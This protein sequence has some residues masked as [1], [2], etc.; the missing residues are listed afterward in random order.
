LLECEISRGIWIVL[1]I[2]CIPPS[3][4][5][6]TDEGMTKIS[7]SHAWRVMR[8]E[9]YTKNGILERDVCTRC[10]ADRICI[11]IEKN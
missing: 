4:A 3:R 11:L 6:K 9:D 8:V 7:N 2:Q 10:G 1:N 5:D